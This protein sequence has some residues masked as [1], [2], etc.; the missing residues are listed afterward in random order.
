MMI[1]RLK[2]PPLFFPSLSEVMLTLYLLQIH[3]PLDVPNL[4][5]AFDYAPSI[6][7]VLI[8]TW[9]VLAVWRS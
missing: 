5:E 8:L 6:D 1:N 7:E 9:I 3:E 4:H 2:I